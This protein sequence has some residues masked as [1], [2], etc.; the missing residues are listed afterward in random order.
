MII[1]FAGSTADNIVV[2][3][4]DDRQNYEL[5][6]QSNTG[7]VVNKQ[8]FTY[9]YQVP[10]EYKVVCLASTAGDRATNLQTD[11]CSF[12]VK[13]IDDQT[14]IERISCPQIIRD[15]VFAEQQ[16]N[17]EWLMV[18]P[19]SVIYNNREQTVSLSQRLRFYIPSDSTKVRVNG[20]DYSSTTAYNLSS[21]IDILVKSDF[22]TERPY[23][24]YTINYPRFSTFKL[25]GVAGTITLDAF[26]YSTCV[27]NV[28]LPRGT[29]VSSLT[30]E[31]TTY[32]ATDKVYIGNAEQTPGVSA[33]DFTRDVTY[34]LVA[35]VPGKPEMQA[36][37]TVVVKISL[38]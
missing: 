4:G 14:E 24:L 26:D 12:T 5:R 1:D 20:N 33:V 13:V 35:T 3:P 19:R 31:F 37:S 25:L 27:I 10:G 38:Q 11:T 15:E 9:S 34:R 28:T 6:D 23:K 16:A 8:R 30:P 7:L 17:D 36:E 21:P 2:Y 22:G 29:D 32:S 18:L